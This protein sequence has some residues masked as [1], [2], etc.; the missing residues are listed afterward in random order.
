MKIKRDAFLYLDGDDSR[1]AQCG[2]CVFGYTHCRLMDNHAVSAE[3]GSCGYYIEGK[4]VLHLAVAKLTARQVG[5]VERRVRCE[6]CRFY[7]STGKCQLF[8][9]LNDVLPQFFSLDE[10]VERHGCCNAQLPE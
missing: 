10:K 2:A 5:Y 8:K 6:N 7:S 3:F 1:F 9:H 4:S